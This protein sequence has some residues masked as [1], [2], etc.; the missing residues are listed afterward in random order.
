MYFE[1]FNIP[2]VNKRRSRVTTQRLQ[3]FFAAKVGEATIVPSLQSKSSIVNTL[4]NIFLDI[5]IYLMFYTEIEEYLVYLGK[6]VVGKC[7]MRGSQCCR[8]EPMRPPA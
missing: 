1:T 7:Y 3:R 5:C 2:A 6:L 4:L 8:A